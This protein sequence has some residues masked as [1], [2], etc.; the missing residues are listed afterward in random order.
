MKR[1][2]LFTML[3]GFVLSCSESPKNEANKVTFEY[4]DI[5]LSEK[6][7]KATESDY[8]KNLGFTD[9][10]VS[11]VS[12]Y[13]K[14]HEFKTLWIN[15]STL[16]EQG[17]SIK[18][19]MAN[20]VSIGLPRN[21]SALKESFNYIQ[22]ELVIT[23]ALC[24]SLYDLKHGYFD[25]EEKK[26]LERKNI[27]LDSMR[28][29]T[30]FKET[31]ELKKAFVAFGPDDTAYVSLA[32]GLRN[33]TDLYPMDTSNFEVMSIK[34]DSVE[35]PIRAAKSLVSKGYL[36]EFSVDTSLLNP[37]LRT[38]QIHNGL[39]PDAVIGKFTSKCL[40]ES[41]EAKVYRILLSME[42]IRT[43]EP[44]PKK[45]IRINIPEYMLRFYE[46]DT[47]RS[48]HNIVTG[49]YDNQTPELTSKL[50]KIVVYP[51]WNV[52]YSISSKEILP[53][54]KYNPNYLAKHNYRI[55]KN[56]VEVDPSTVNWKPIKQN[57]FPFKVV[58]DP[59]PSNSLGILKFDFYN[60]H[61][62]YFHDTP[63]KG[64]FGA[65]VRSYSHGCMRTQY[66][67]DLAKKILE[68]DYIPYKRNEMLPDSLDSILAREENYEIKLIN[69]IPIYIEYRTVVS[70]NQ[71][72]IV[73]HDVYGRDE[74]YLKI[75]MD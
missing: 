47:L 49:T 66:P 46:D 14:Q 52:P 18:E 16:S 44:Y 56:G 70:K 9:D 30:S 20:P 33:F 42:K 31:D 25:L 26:Y 32:N 59:G 50:R 71:H 6:I 24:Q 3:F 8:L 17:R 4:Q 29:L 68:Y 36:K 48:E 21:R 19:L 55:Y 40:N 72:M 7:K 45:F 57:A 51:Y 53:A 5:P 75:L 67:L 12:D 43:H 41:T 34:K 10:D 28:F 38:F 60:E 73:H 62:V 74:E 69:R 1:L 64:L 35:A 63:A 37:A 23:L 13:Y 39:K 22:D 65:D 61:S 2:L 54:V 58:Q 11:L 27:T 15:D